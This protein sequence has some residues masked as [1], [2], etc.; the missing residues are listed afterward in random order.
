MSEQI[1]QILEPVL[2]AIITAIVTIILTAITAGKNLIINWIKSK[3]NANQQALIDRVA[4]EAYAYAEQWAEYEGKDK[5]ICAIDFVQR[6][7]K[8]VGITISQQKITA[9]IQSAWEQFGR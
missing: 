7:L 8:E 1:T 2:L 9:A 4:S 3:T 5:L 6:E